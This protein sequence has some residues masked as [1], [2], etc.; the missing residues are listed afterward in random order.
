MNYLPPGPTPLI[1]AILAQYH[2]TIPSVYK[3]RLLLSW[4]SPNEA[5]PPSTPAIA[6]SREESEPAIT[7]S[8]KFYVY[9][10]ALQLAFCQPPGSVLGAVVGWVAGYA[11]R[12]ELMP[13]GR[14]RYPL[15]LFEKSRNAGEGGYEGL[16]RV[17]RGGEQQGGAADGPATE[18]PTGADGRRPLSTQILDQFRGGL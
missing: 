18:A 3:F 15:W 13:W 5:D 10:V 17:A 11:W 8:D 1:F 14:W 6:A 4:K 16:R 9:I 12:T 2:A 7:L